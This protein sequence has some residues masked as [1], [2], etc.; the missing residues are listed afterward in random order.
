M[1]M[2]PVTPFRAYDS[3]YAVG[4]PPGRVFN[5]TTRL[6]DLNPPAAYE[7]ALV[8]VTYAATAGAGF[9]R[10]WATRTLRP[11]TSSL[12][13]DT[14]GTVAAN[15]MVVPLAADGT[16]VLESTTTA[17]VVIDVM[18]WFDESG[19]TDDGRFVALAPARLADTRLP[20][21][22]ALDSGSPNP[23]TATA[24]GFDVE[25]AGLL[26]VPADGTVSAVALS[27]AAI[28]T[29]AFA[30]WVSVYPG[31]GTFPGTS[32]VNVR[33]GEVRANLVVVPLEGASFISL[34]NLNIDDVVIDVVGTRVPLGF[35]RMQAQTPAAVTMPVPPASAVVQNLTV[36]RT[37]ARGHLTTHPTAAT[38]NV[39]NLNYDG[40]NQ[41][42]AVLA[43]TQLPGDRVMHYTSHVATDFVVDLLGYFTS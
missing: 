38:P 35:G 39:S 27:V 2:I 26:D 17:R 40:A 12:N 23:W 42:R 8:N 14:P 5:A 3:G 11:E 33:R 6:I 30:G 41:I 31:G 16:F 4:T 28:P 18:A 29:D 13:A 37:S 1:K 43:F 19:N 36:A 15:A 20:A 24:D 22:V 21:S 25:V 9:V 34:R 7:A 10:T 32:N